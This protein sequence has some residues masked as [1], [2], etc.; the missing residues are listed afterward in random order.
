MQMLKK[1]LILISV[2]TS[3]NLAMAKDAIPLPPMVDSKQQDSINQ[4]KSSQEDANPEIPKGSK[5]KKEKSAVKKIPIKIGL[6]KTEDDMYLSLVSTLCIFI[7]EENDTSCRIKQFNDPIE[8]MNSM[9]S[10]DV[11]ILMTNSILAKYTADGSP[12]FYDKNM[13]V[14]KMRFVASFFDEKLAILANRDL[15]NQNLDDL[16]KASIN[17]GKNFT[18]ERL[19]FNEILR[20]KNWTIADFKR[21]AELENSE[22]LKAICDKTIDSTIIIGEDMNQ[23]MKDITRLCEV[24]IVPITN[25]VINL[26]KD[27]ARFL[28]SKI[29]GG[30]YIGIPRDI[31]TIATKAILI[32]TSDSSSWQIDKLLQI[33]KDNINKIR[34]L[35]QSLKDLKIE[36]IV[37]EGKIAP[38]HN[39]VITF[40]ERN[41]LKQEN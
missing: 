40:M 38:L 41:N 17:I 33:I 32:T 21:S 20:V 27:D 14:K 26:F 39:G 5:S 28:Q 30:M 37:S 9:L 22:E 7:N 31:D 25:D 29:I 23:Y 34:L 13:Q 36:S 10:G 24:E 1:I 12:P 8:A 19:F 4:I 16:K 35:H 3:Y 11:D 15:N 2:I 6:S 18:K